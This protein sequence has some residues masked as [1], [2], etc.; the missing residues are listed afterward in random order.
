MP[1]T[2]SLDIGNHSIGV[3]CIS[4]LE[5]I[6]H[7]QDIY[8]YSVTYSD[9][10]GPD[11]ICSYR[12]TEIANLNPVM[13][14]FKAKYSEGALKLTQSGID[15]FLKAN[16][17]F[18]AARPGVPRNRAKCRKCGQRIQSYYRH[19]YVAC[20]CGAIAVDGGYEYSRRGG[21]TKDFIE[22]PE[23]WQT[24]RKGPK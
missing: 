21:D 9:A 5:G 22:L 7:G 16:P 18:V 13:A 24:R 6:T 14:I 15:A 20:K 2:V 11:S 8:R 23:K 19:D 12:S 3:L 1:L 4:R 10:V 17:A